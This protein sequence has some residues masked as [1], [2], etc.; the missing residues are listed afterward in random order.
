MKNYILKRLTQL[1]PILFGITFLTFALLYLSPGDPA[2]KK[3]SATGVAVSNEVLKI[4]QEEM[5]LNRPLISQYTSWLLNLLKGD[6]GISYKDGTPVAYKLAKGMKYTFL[7]SLSAFVLATG[8]SLPLGIYTAIR[9]NHFSDYCIRFICFAGNAVPNFL[10]AIVLIYFLCIRMKLFPVI[11]GKNVRGLF[12]P[13]LS[14]ALPLA[15]RFIRQI[16]AAVLTELEADYVS[17]GRSRGVKEKYLLFGN[18]VH[19]AM[20]S[21]ITVL[22]ISIGTLFGGSVV[23]E[24][25]FM[26]PGIGKLAMDSIT[27]RDYPVLQGIVII[28]AII[29]VIVNLEV[30]IICR[31]L[32][33]RIKEQ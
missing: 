33:P 13:A 10:L 17:G 26:W 14:L 32:D 28:M 30:D 7:L 6:M 8:V 11:A 5:G 22:G 24:S 20:K 16:R 29:Y 21:I 19:N 27:A 1:I 25:I 18:V 3:L 15:S 9:K 31:R 4:T 2:Q 12:L 23:I